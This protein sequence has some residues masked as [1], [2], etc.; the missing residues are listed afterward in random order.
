MRLNSIK[1][2][3]IILK[4]CNE[5]NIDINRPFQNSSFADKRVHLLLKLINGAEDYSQKSDFQLLGD[6]MFLFTSACYYLFKDFDIPNEDYIDRLLLMP[7]GPDENGSIETEFISFFNKDYQKVF[8]IE[9]D[10]IFGYQS[11]LSNNLLAFDFPNDSYLQYKDPIAIHLQFL[12]STQRAI[13]VPDYYDFAAYFVFMF[14]EMFV[15]K[16]NMKLLKSVSDRIIDDIF[17]ATLEFNLHLS[18]DTL[19]EIVYD[20]I[21][22]PYIPQLRHRYFEYLYKE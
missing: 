1:A 14:I 7:G 20:N 12:Y 3:S 5:L 16:M 9:K 10:D 15:N 21:A 2:A 11:I 22:N 6:R 13:T 4:A 18:K 19:T 17:K 8:T